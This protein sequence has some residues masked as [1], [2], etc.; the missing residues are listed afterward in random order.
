VL[1]VAAVLVAGCTWSGSA[2]RAGQPAVG[3]DGCTGV[4]YDDVRGP[5][6]EYGD[7]TLADFPGS[8][9]MCA[10]YWL[11]G[12]N[13]RL[14]PQG[15]ALDG[16]TIWVSGYRFHPGVGHR[17]CLVLRIDRRTGRRLA[18]VTPVEGAVEGRDPTYCR[19][20]GGLAL[21]DEGLWVVETMRLW[22][23]DPDLVGSADPVQRVWSIVA[24]LR[25]STLVDDEGRLGFGQFLTDGR[26]GPVD[27]FRTSDLLEPGVVELVAGDPGTGQ[28]GPVRRDR[29][30]AYLQGGTLG[31]RGLYL[32]QS[33][34]RC[35]VLR[36][37]GGR[38]VEIGPGTE[39]LEFDDAGD[40]WT[41]SESGAR[42]YQ[43]RG[44]RPLVPM[45]ARF[46]ARQLLDGPHPACD[47]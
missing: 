42:T 37:P 20:G 33:N 21:T 15:L 38:R 25:G 5:R 13:R 32:T 36:T 22:L 7:R 43:H 11:P 14:V 23:L 9:T 24:P 12:A 1:L 39:D 47:L 31:P 44:G 40:L 27:W 26:R 19:H 6:I 34:T 46:D 45:L 28:A 10:G 8:G 18:Q 35:G 17:Q 4:A 41:V 29:G 2:P 16:D 30:V 3:R